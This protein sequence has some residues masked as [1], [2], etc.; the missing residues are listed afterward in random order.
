MANGNPVRKRRE[1]RASFEGGV[2]AA[3]RNKAGMTQRD[4]ADA[5]GVDRSLI[6]QFERGWCNVSDAVLGDIAAVLGIP[7]GLLEQ[8]SA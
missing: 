7:V 8:E 3:Y 2:C 5:V 6:G 4:L 1:R